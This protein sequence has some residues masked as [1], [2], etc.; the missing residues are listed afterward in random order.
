MN[1]SKKKNILRYNLGGSKVNPNNYLTISSYH[2]PGML[3]TLEQIKTENDQDCYVIFPGYNKKA[4]GDAQCCCTG[5][6][7]L[8]EDSKMIKYTDTIEQ[9]NEKIAIEATFR[10]AGEELGL[11]PTNMNGLILREKINEN[12]KK[13][14]W[15]SVNANHMKNITLKET[16]NIRRYG[17][18][19]KN[20][21]I[22][23]AVYG[24]RKKIKNLLSNC[25]YQLP[26]NDGINYYLAIQIDEALK[27]V[28][29]I[30][31]RNANSQPIKWL[32][33]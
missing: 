33:V 19:D 20:F 22:G 15:F 14:Y 12:K 6:V 5:R 29:V 28:N 26:N 21:R 31:E 18:D 30:L 13:Y 17:Y 16:K 10:E 27:I 1:C 2:M 25:K 3:E 9:K 24:T 23:L 11:L 4:G 32:L 7:K 8:H